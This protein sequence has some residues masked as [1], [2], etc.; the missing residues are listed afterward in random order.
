MNAPMS[1]GNHP[2]SKI[3]ST[4]NLYTLADEIAFNYMLYAYIREFNYFAWIDNDF[5]G[6]YLVVIELLRVVYERVTGSIMVYY[7]M[8]WRRLDPTR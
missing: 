4:N 5:M 8:V 3:L 2:I 7:L 6:I 1:V